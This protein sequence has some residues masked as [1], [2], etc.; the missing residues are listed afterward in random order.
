V[1]LGRPLVRKPGA[2]AVVVGLF[3][4]VGLGRVS[5]FVAL[6]VGAAVALYL[7]RTNRL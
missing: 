3:L 7:S 6:P 4:A 5:L 2:V 1:K